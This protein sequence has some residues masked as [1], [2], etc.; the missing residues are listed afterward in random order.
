MLAYG[1]QH[2]GEDVYLQQLNAVE[3]LKIEKQNP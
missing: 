2:S 1:N 3:K